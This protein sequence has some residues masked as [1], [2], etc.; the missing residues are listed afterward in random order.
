MSTP[1]FAEQL[2]LLPPIAHL[3]AVE[4]LDAAGTVVATLPQDLKFGGEKTLFEIGDETTDPDKQISFYGDLYNFVEL[5]GAYFVLKNVF[6]A[7]GAVGVVIEVVG[8]GFFL[9]HILRKGRL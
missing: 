5:T 8:G 3:A 7:A 6:N 2:A 4:L 9:I 1:T